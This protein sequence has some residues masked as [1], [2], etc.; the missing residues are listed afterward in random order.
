MKIRKPLI[1]LAVASALLPATILPVAAQGL[2]GKSIEI[3]YTLK[4]CFPNEPCRRAQVHFYDYVGSAGHLYEFTG[5]Q[6]GDVYTFG[7]RAPDGRLYTVQ[8]NRLSFQNG[9]A[10]RTYSVK[11]K[12]CS[13][14]DKWSDND[15]HP[16]QVE[17]LI[18]IV[19]DG[20]P[21]E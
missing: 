3:S 6:K 17:N 16:N 19:T 5:P 14:S 11:G 9:G 20:P 18:C 13:I 4:V 1:I 2:V 10:T 15:R 12:S 8:G 21:P 7:V